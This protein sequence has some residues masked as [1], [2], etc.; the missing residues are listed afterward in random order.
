[1][2]GLMRNLAT[3]HD[4]ALVII[5]FLQADCKNTEL[6]SELLSLRKDLSLSWD[7]ETDCSDDGDI[8]CDGHSASPIS[9]A[10]GEIRP[11]VELDRQ[12]NQADI[13]AIH[14]VAIGLRAIADQLH[15][16]V[17]AQAT[18]NLRSSIETCPTDQW[19]DHFNRVVT[20]AMIQGVGLEHHPQEQVVVALSLTL[21]KGVCQHTPR[22]LRSLF[23]TAL[24]YINGPRLS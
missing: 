2:D 21:V 11:S 8:E 17:V 23:S 5:S 3:E 24:E 1:M 22:L 14:D 12:D 18:Q 13:E 20:R 4:V 9:A 6:S 15:Q 10:L 16:E 19:K 7:A